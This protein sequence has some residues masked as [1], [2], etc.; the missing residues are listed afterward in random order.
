MTALLQDAI[1]AAKPESNTARTSTTSHAFVATIALPATT[2]ISVA[3]PAVAGRSVR[4]PHLPVIDPFTD[5]H[6]WASLDEGCNNNCHGEKLALNAE[7]KLAAYGFEMIWL[8]RRERTYDG[9]GNAKIIAK[10]KRMFPFVLAWDDNVP[11]LGTV[12]THEMAGDNA[13]LI[14]NSA[15]ANLGL[16]KDM[17]KGECRLSR[18]PDHVM[19]MAIDSKTGLLLVCLSRFDCLRKKGTKKCVPP[20]FRQFLIN[21]DNM[22]PPDSDEESS[23][24]AAVAFVARRR[25]RS[26]SRG[27]G[28]TL[29]SVLAAG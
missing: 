8:H 15:Q 29:C 4:Y 19:P 3:N 14:S 26:E 13:L 7:Q 27:D 21:P 22:T 1:D 6:I 18:R 28:S 24:S 2:S 10:G 11:M 5:K 25:K 17:G 23:H 12:E 9:I 16:I 20:N